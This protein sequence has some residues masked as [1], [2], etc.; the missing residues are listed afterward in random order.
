[1]T[2]VVAL[3]ADITP[4]Q[5]E[6]LRA[7]GASDYLTK[8]IDVARFLAV[9]DR[10]L[11]TGRGEAMNDLSLQDARILIVDDQEATV[12]FLEGQLQEGGYRRY[13]NLRDPRAV[14]EAYD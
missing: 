6:R 2:P 14:G 7:A 10:F 4:H 1:G 12:L 5:I 3:S 9:L 13:L 8:P 11:Q